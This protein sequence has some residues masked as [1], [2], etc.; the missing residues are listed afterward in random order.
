M[1]Y[2]VLA[3]QIGFD[4]VVAFVLRIAGAVVE[5]VMKRLWQRKRRPEAV[6]PPAEAHDE[7]RVDLTVVS[8]ST[9]T[10]TVSGIWDEGRSLPEGGREP[11]E[12]PGS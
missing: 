10:I 6:E 12:A 2:Q 9:E 11:P 4:K 8:I 7:V 3:K 1:D 5:A